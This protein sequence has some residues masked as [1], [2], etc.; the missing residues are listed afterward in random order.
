MS[1]G[2]ADKGKGDKMKMER[3]NNKKKICFREIN[4]KEMF[5]KREEVEERFKN[6]K[7]RQMKATY[8]NLAEPEPAG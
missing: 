6:W 4:M 2:L 3:G 7:E 8:K 5:F 1:Q